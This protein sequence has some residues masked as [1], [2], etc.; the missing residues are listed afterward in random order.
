M[1]RHSWLCLG[2]FRK[3]ASEAMF[4]SDWAEWTKV[5]PAATGATWSCLMRVGRCRIRNNIWLLLKT[6]ATG[7]IRSNSWPG[8]RRRGVASTALSRVAKGAISSNPWI[9]LGIMG[10]RQHQKQLPALLEKR[11]KVKARAWGAPAWL[12][13]TSAAAGSVHGEHKNAA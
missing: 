4:G 10:G 3:A 7:T 2:E 6:S 13:H 8:L 9:G 11:L 1:R 5:A 12:S